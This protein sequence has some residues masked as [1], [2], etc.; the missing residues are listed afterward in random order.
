MWPLISPPAFISSRSTLDRTRWVK[1]IRSVKPT[2]APYDYQWNGGRSFSF[3]LSKASRPRGFK[4]D[5]SP[6]IA[7]IRASCQ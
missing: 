4:P 3:P 1:P 5:S 7:R 6:C 2:F